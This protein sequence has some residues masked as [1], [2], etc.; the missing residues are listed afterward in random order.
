MLERR[1]RATFI[2]DITFLFS[3]LLHVHHHIVRFLFLGFVFFFFLL[4]HFVVNK[5]YNIF[6]RNFMFLPT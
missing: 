3:L 4:L 1:L 2:L 5:F 6:V